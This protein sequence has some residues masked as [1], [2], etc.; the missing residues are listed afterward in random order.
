MCLCVV[1][2]V[3]FFRFS[4]GLLHRL[5]TISIIIIITIIIIFRCFYS[6]VIS[7]F[8]ICDNENKTT[9]GES[10]TADVYSFLHCIFFLMFFLISDMTIDEYSSSKCMLICFNSSHLLLFD[11]N[12][13]IHLLPARLSTTTVILK[14]LVDRQ[15]FTP[16]SHPSFFAEPNE[17]FFIFNNEKFCHA[18]SIQ[19]CRRS[20]R[21]YN[22]HVGNSRSFV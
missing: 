20:P 8:G 18:E 16:S 1:Q 14:S 3:F 4:S 12:K 9:L 10:S 6:F 7:L 21:K 17:Y 11:L 13:W 15:I 2:T 22:Q 19:F 5:S